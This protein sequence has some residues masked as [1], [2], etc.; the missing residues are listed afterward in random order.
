MTQAPCNGDHGL[1]PDRRDPDGLRELLEQTRDN[2]VKLLADVART[3]RRLRVQAAE[4]IVEIEWGDDGT[5]AAVTAPAATPATGAVAE[6]EVPPGV[7]LTA[8]TVGV[9]YR[10]PEP[11]AA[12]F[13]AEGDVVQVGQQVG[14]VEVMKLMIPV[15]AE[16]SGTVVEVLKD[17][18]APVE[19]G[20]PLFALSTEGS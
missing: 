15:E 13:V 10:A 9:F 17:D 16:R 4:I 7:F 1:W 5:P 6:P 19:Y 14:T 11:S 18:G 12:P 2:V 20:E 8:P 3:P